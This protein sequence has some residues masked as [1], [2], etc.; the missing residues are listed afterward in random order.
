MAI[1]MNSC[2]NVLVNVI[3]KKK[4]KPERSLDGWGS[5]ITSVGVAFARD[6]LSHSQRQQRLKRS[7][8]ML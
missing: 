1:N 2:P 4:I 3:K 6:V 8:L 5:I 7:E